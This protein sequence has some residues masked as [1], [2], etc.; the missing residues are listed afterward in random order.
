VNGQI[1]ADAAWDADAQIDLH[2]VNGDCDLT[3]P[4][5]FSAKASAR[6]IN[7]SVTDPQGKTITRQFSGWQGT[8]GP[9]TTST[10]GE[11][12]AEIAFHTVNGHLRMHSGPATA[13]ATQYAKQAAGAPSTPVEPEA[14]PVQVKV[15]QA[16]PQQ[17][18]QEAKSP[19]TQL[20]IL[21]RVERGELTVQ[22]AIERLE[23]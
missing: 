6:G 11:P 21:Q 14:E 8:I 20:E 13:T 12:R 7:V 16:P 9:K 4:A 18:P 23:G 22:E 15:A 1:K 19:R 3:V 10:D 2:T 5:G 17:A